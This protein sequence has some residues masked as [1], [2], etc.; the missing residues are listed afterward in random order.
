MGGKVSEQETAAGLWA[1]LESLYM[2][3]TL[4][5]K[6]LLKQRLFSLR[7]QEGTSLKDHLEKLNT[8][9]LDLRNIDVYVD[10]EDAVLILLVSLPAS[11]ENF[12]ESMTNVVGLFA[13]SNQGFVKGKKKFP[14]KQFKRGS[15]LGDVCHY[16]KE[17]G[18]WKTDCPKKRQGQFNA[19]G[20]AAVAESSTKSEEDIALVVDNHTF[21]TDV[22]ILDSGASYHICPKREWFSTYEQ[23]D[24]GNIFMANNS[25]CKVVGIGSV[26]IRTHDGKFCTL[27]DVRY[28]PLMTKNLISLSLLDRKGFSFKGEGGVINVCR[29]SE[30]ILKGVKQG[31]LYFLQGGTLLDSA[32]VASSVVENDNMTKLWHMRLGHMSE[33]GMQILARDNLLGVQK[34]KDLGFCEHCVFGKLHRNKF[35]KATHRTKGK[36]DYIHSDCWVLHELNLWEVTGIF[37]H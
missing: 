29:G 2:T 16:C 26:K 31:T 13:N 5:N 15:K 30:V 1:K 33:R 8:I 25:V 4:T 10:D 27:E 12:K 9:L 34:L 7:M 20:T 24:G 22:W 18:H 37:Y 23:V 32:T 17:K 28:V 19:S 21:Y 35:P 11:Y 14:K 36:L 6:L 3:R